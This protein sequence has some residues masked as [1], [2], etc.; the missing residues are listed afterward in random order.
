MRRRAVWFLTVALAS[1][2]LL[3]PG[4]SSAQQPA[5]SE[6]Q[7]TTEPCDHAIS[8]EWKRARAQDDAP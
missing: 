7:A 8:A 4:A 5:Q 2:A 1:A 3:L 6:T